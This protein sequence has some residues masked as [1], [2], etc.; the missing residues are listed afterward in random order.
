MKVAIVQ[1]FGCSIGLAKIRYAVFLEEE[2][3]K[4]LDCLSDY[5]ASSVQEIENKLEVNGIC[6]FGHADWI[7]QIIQQLTD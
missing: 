6:L 1:E 5:R 4:V 7:Q 3:T 2:Y